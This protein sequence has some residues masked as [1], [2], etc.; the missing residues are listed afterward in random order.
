MLKNFFKILFLLIFWSTASNVVAQ[1]TFQNLGAVFEGTSKELTSVGAEL[2]D[3]SSQ[4]KKIQSELA[5]NNTTLNIT[6]SGA[7]L[8]RIDVIESE[9]RT[10]ISQI[11]KLR[12]RIEDIAN[13]STNR[14]GDLEFRIVE[15]EGGDITQLG[16]PRPIGGSADWTLNNTN[17]GAEITIIEKSNYKTALDSLNVGNFE[18]A[19]QQFDKLVI[20]FPGGPL[21]SAAYYSKGEAF[22]GLNK[23]KSA[24]HSFLESF[25]SDPSGEVAPKALYKLGVSLGKLQKIE[26]ACKTLLEVGLLFSKNKIVLDANNEMQILGCM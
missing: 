25:K 8:M 16:Q 6:P 1:N 19:V 4:I 15:L 12:F 24:G 21:I 26:E 5:E 17:D 18:L 9:V 14:I 22:I 2:E 7:A 13:D 11:E 3:L 23:W 20:E 10:L